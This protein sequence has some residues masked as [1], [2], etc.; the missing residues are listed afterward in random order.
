[1][2]SA[3]PWYQE[4][5][6]EQAAELPSLAQVLEQRLAAEL[7]EDIDRVDS[8]INEITENEIDDAVFA[9]EGDGRFGTL[10]GKRKKTGSF[11][12]G[13]DDAQHAQM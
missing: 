7:G 8:G 12:S 4:V 11:T 6:F 5:A 1:M 3:V 9:A 10:A 2:A 13:E